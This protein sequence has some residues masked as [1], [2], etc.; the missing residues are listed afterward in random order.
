MASWVIDVVLSVFGLILALYIFL[1]KKKAKKYG[2]TKEELSEIWAYV[3]K[4]REMREKL[5][6]DFISLSKEVE[7]NKQRVHE[8]FVFISTM[9]ADLKTMFQEQTDDIKELIGTLTEKF[10]KYNYCMQEM[11][12]KLVAHMAENGIRNEFRK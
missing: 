7:M 1:D 4:S 3:T 5:E 6:R 10:D 11:N 12:L 9:Q 8:Q 2:E